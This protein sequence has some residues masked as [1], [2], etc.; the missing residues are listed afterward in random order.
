M[1]RAF[2]VGMIIAMVVVACGGTDKQA[3]SGDVRQSSDGTAVDAIGDTQD[4]QGVDHRA[5]LQAV[6]ETSEPEV[7]ACKPN[8][9]ECGLD[10]GCGGNCECSADRECLAVSDEPVNQCLPTCETICTG[11]VCGKVYRFDD[12]WACECGTCDDGNPCTD[13]TCDGMVGF[14][15]NRECAF[16]P[17]DTNPCDDG[18]ETTQDLCTDGECVS[19]AC[20]S[21]CVDKECGD[22]GCGGQCGTCP[23]EETCTEESLCK[24]ILPGSCDGKCNVY[25]GIAGF[26]ECDV[27]CFDAEDCCE[28]I[29]IVCWEEISNFCDPP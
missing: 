19:T 20:T 3:P 13:D 21:D 23:A 9:D 18:D 1:T 28:D 5:E 11:V 8:C 29:C 16:T 2:S 25:E 7:D 6:D 14:P 17:N 15:E 10:D 26:C 4:L 12:E 24:L 22:D 27:G